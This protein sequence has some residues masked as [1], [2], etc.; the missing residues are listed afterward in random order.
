MSKYTFAEEIKG[1]NFWLIAATDVE[2]AEEFATIV[3][4]NAEEF[5][6]L[7]HTSQINTK[8]KAI[9]EIN[10]YAEKR[11][12]GGMFFYFIVDAKN[13]ILGFAGIKIK[14][15]NVAE[16]CYWL[17]KTQYGKGFAVQAMKLLEKEVFKAGF[18]RFE[19]WCHA[20][21]LPSIRVP[22]RLG[23]KLD[24][25]LSKAEYLFGTYHDVEVFVKK[26]R[27]NDNNC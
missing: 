27:I 8:N 25:V 2:R 18:Q 7:P 14:D 9:E 26:G 6:F 5:K 23:Y 15:D 4:G 24:R 22:Q 13:K 12:N 21:N 16:G 19:I 10:N 3:Q 20:G 11:R 1:N 17:D